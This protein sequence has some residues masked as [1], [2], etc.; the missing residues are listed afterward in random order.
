[1]NLNVQ[2]KTATASTTKLAVA[3]AFLGVAALAAAAASMPNN[4][5]S[6][7]SYGFE[8]YPLA[9]EEPLIKKFELQITPD[10]AVSVT[11]SFGWNTLNPYIDLENTNAF[12][13]TTDKNTVSARITIPDAYQGKTP[14]SYGFGVVYNQFPFPNFNNDVVNPFKSEVLDKDVIVWS[15]KSR[16]TLSLDPVL[17][18]TGYMTFFALVKNGTIIM[19]PAIGADDMTYIIMKNV[20]STPATPSSTLPITGTSSVIIESAY[21]ATTVDSILTPSSVPIQVG[22]WKLTAKNGPVKLNKFTF[23]LVDENKKLVTDSKDFGAFSLYDAANMTSPLAMSTYQS[24]IGKGIVQFTIPNTVILQKDTPTYLV[25]KAPVNGS[26]IMKPNAIR[27]W[28]MRVTAPASVTF[29]D[30]NSGQLLTNNQ[31]FFSSN[32]TSFAPGSVQTHNYNLLH[33]AAPIITAINSTKNL[34]IS[35]NAQLF[36]FTVSNP[37]DRDLRVS[38]MSIMA[39]ASGLSNSLLSN[40]SST[41]PY[42]YAKVKDWRLWEANSAGGLGMNLAAT[43]TC[44]FAVVKGVPGC[45]SGLGYSIYANFNKNNQINKSFE[46]LFIAPGASRTFIMTADTTGILTNKTAGMVWYVSNMQG[47]TGFDRYD[48]TKT[49]NTGSL[50]Y[51]YTPVGSTK[52]LGPFTYSDSYIVQG[53]VLSKTL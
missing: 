31:M 13:K 7:M 40:P 50:T 52:E 9:K 15:S 42:V 30:A 24:G 26:G 22:K 20:S 6:P 39:F 48:N 2:T 1:M 19:S 36:K 29:T 37:G 5:G 12:L 25:M 4:S 11:S 23:Q 46:N 8:N 38:D 27:S 32:T 51:Y 10:K 43:S 44:E 33:N 14:V 34:P 21:D 18:K 28:V 3:F 49:W 35:T 47:Y 41:E 16:I 17:S 53:E 45:V